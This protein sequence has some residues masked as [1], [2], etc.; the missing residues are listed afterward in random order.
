MQY[1]YRKV[2]EDY[3]FHDLSVDLK[4]KK[5]KKEGKWQIRIKM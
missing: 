4:K 1:K 5:D 3:A 2:K